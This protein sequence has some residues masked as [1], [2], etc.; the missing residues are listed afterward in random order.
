MSPGYRG[1]PLLQPCLVASSI[2]RGHVL[3]KVGRGIRLEQ[4]T[5]AVGHTGGAIT[6]LPV[7]LLLKECLCCLPLRITIAVMPRVVFG[8]AVGNPVGDTSTRACRP[9]IRVNLHGGCLAHGFSPS[10]RVTE[11]VGGCCFI[12]CSP[13]FEG[14]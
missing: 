14:V 12:V 6:A 9:F 1:S 3:Q 2:L 10:R 8:V 11:I 13:L 5:I 4:D 7:Y